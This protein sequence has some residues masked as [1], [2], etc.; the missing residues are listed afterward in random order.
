M[1]LWIGLAPDEP[2]EGPPI[3]HG[4]EA[5]F[6]GGYVVAV[7]RER[8]GH[9]DRLSGPLVVRANDRLRVEVD[10]DRDTPIVAG[11]LGRD[12]AWTPLLTPAWLSPGAH[13]SER[14]A[15]FD[16]APVDAV[17]LV[18]SPDDVAHA[19]QTRDFA[20]VVAWSVRSEPHE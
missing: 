19:R 16:E 3:A 9:Q 6:K 15:R 12:G 5:R 14:A 4:V 13:F 8:D 7:V 18:G 11:L 17:L 10:V 2:L 20:S 1:I